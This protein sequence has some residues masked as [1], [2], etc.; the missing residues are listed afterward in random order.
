MT[1]P[2]SAVKDTHNT[3]TH[4]PT[5]SWHDIESVKTLAKVAAV[6]RVVHGSIT[7]TVAVV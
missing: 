3:C 5:A 4:F 2:K 6:A 1:H 7:G